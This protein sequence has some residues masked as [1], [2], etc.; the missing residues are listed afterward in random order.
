MCAYRVCAFFFALETSGGSC[1][2]AR[3]REHDDDLAK[4]QR[5][6]KRAEEHDRC[7]GQVLSLGFRRG[8]TK[9]GQKEI[10]LNLEK[11]SAASRNNA[12]FRGNRWIESKIEAGDL[13]ET[14][15][16]G[17][18]ACSS[19]PTQA[20]RLPRLAPRL[21]PLYG[22]VLAEQHGHD[23]VEEASVVARVGA[24]VEA[25]RGKRRRVAVPTD[26]A[27]DELCAHALCRIGLQSRTDAHVSF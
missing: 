9:D 6:E 14:W 26:R 15:C 11:W 13:G 24:K 20:A 17:C 4:E 5:E 27:P 21:R 3:L 8:C 23:H 1:V 18:A 19:R 2:A 22:P 12:N 16:Y 7:R 25:G 10:W